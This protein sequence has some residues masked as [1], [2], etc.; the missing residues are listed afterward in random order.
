M[1]NSDNAKKRFKEEIGGS[2]GNN[3]IRRKRNR[4]KGFWLLS[5]FIFI[6]MLIIHT[7]VV[8]IDSGTAILGDGEMQ[9]EE[10]HFYTPPNTQV[11]VKTGGSYAQ[12]NDIILHFGDHTVELE[13]R[14]SYSFNTDD[15]GYSSIYMT[16]QSGTFRYSV[17]YAEYY[18]ISQFFL[19]FT[20][21]SVLLMSVLLVISNLYIRKK[22]NSKIKSI[23][24]YF[25]II[26]LCLLG[27]I[28]YELIQLLSL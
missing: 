6:T 19:M 9:S 8:R 22:N 2:F 1:S 21:Y 24:S 10:F 27:V 3:I 7:S 15:G 12:Q 18:S 16:G 25:V 26:S 11:I 23:I 20:G 5:I 13:H 17:Y 28:T 14:G 4:I